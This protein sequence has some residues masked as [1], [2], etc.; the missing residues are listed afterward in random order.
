M[1][2]RL[3]RILKEIKTECGDSNASSDDDGQFVL[4]LILLLIIIAFFNKAVL[5]YICVLQIRN[6]TRLSSAKKTFIKQT[7]Q[8]LILLHIVDISLW[9]AAPQSP[10]SPTSTVSLRVLPSLSTQ[11]MRTTGQ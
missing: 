1:R 5:R 3:S 9:T 7:A 6:I 4:S 11:D 2:R 8:L 10:S